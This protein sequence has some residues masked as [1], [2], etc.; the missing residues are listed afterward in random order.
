MVRHRDEATVHSK[1]SKSGT[2]LAELSLATRP[3]V[4]QLRGP[5]L[6]TLGPSTSLQPAVTRDAHRFI[7]EAKAWID[8]M[9]QLLRNVAA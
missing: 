5:R 7:R 1:I 9:E 3:A 6:L 8:R 2:V 4:G